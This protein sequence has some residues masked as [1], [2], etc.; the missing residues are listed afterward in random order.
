MG[1]T[2]VRGWGGPRELHEATGEMCRQA[3]AQVGKLV[4]DSDRPKEVSFGI[5]AEIGC[6]KCYRNISALSAE[7]P[8]DQ[9]RPK[10]AIS[11]ENDY[12]GQKYL[13]GQKNCML[14]QHM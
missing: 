6:L 5:S 9:F 14:L 4:L 2:H 10:E 1:A 11:A 8:K 7:R 13:F 3:C 12:F